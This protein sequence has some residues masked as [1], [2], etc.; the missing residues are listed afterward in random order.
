MMD[1]GECAN[2][3]KQQF[4]S[5]FDKQY[6]VVEDQVISASDGTHWAVTEDFAAITGMAIYCVGHSTV[7]ATDMLVL[8]PLRLGEGTGSAWGGGS[9]WG[10]V[11]DFGRAM[12]FIP[13]GKASPT[14]GA[15]AK[16][17]GTAVKASPA[18]QKVV[19]AA[20][21]VANWEI[22]PVRKVGEAPL[23][24]NAWE[25]IGQFPD[26]SAEYGNCV[27]TSVMRVAIHTRH[28]WYMDA[29]GLAKALGIKL[30]DLLDG[31]FSIEYLQAL[32][33]VWT[34]LK[35]PAR[36]VDIGEL[37]NKNRWMTPEQVLETALPKKK[38]V[39]LF[40]VRRAVQE[41]DK[42]VMKGH[43]MYAA[44]APDGTLRIVDRSGIVVKELKDLAPT[45]TRP[46]Y[47][48][49]AEWEFYEG[50]A[51]WFVPNA[52]LDIAT[53][54]S[55]AHKAATKHVKLLFQVAVRPAVCIPGRSAK[56]N[57]EADAHRPAPKH[58]V[59]K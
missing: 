20:N 27:W 15:A 14:L 19:K 7:D 22:V 41:G 34:K 47:K 6:K 1:A 58:P 2:W 46:G 53:I 26:P 52:G 17:F 23:S 57:A 4:E 54:H 40:N 8:D 3:G 16:E 32:E 55:A 59:S 44:R 25:R 51:A 45:A 49:A 5:W 18:G 29:Q 21:K 13:L 11:A 36:K 24:T 39:L 33:Q 28:R 48:H 37:L 35:I 38:G 31:K 42:T 43:A 12:S 10:Y 9:K 30:G 56:A 50:D